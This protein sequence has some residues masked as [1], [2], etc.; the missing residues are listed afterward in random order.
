MRHIFVLLFGFFS[1]QAAF[2][3]KETADD[4]IVFDFSKMTIQSLGVYNPEKDGEQM[5]LKAEF[6]ARK[7]GLS[8]LNGYFTESCEGIDSTKLGVKNSWESSFHS[9]GTEI[10]ANGVLVV[11][12]Q[13]LVREVFRGPAV[14]S[15]PLKTQK[16]EKI[17][18]SLPANVPSR[19]V[20]C[21]TIELTYGNNQKVY[22]LPNQTAKQP[23]QGRMIELVLDSQKGEFRLKNLDDASALPEFKPISIGANGFDVVP[24]V[25][26]VSG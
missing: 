3:L 19:F 25:V 2:A 15:K 7:K 23:V 8:K 5:G 9:Q 20:R 13:A 12:L 18:F 24:I 26:A 14:K 22:L 1:C 17:L 21:G 11:P 16:D 10:Y 4:K 6:T